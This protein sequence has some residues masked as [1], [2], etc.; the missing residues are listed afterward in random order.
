MLNLKTLI[1][2]LFF[3]AL[4]ITASFIKTQTLIIEKK[5]IEKKKEITVLEKNL[6]ESKLDF[7]YLSSPKELEEK[8]KNISDLNLDTIK[9]SNIYNSFQD[10]F[11][12]YKK[13]SEKK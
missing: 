2:F 9:I 6:Y 12:Q 7:Y 11:N 5:I 1:F 13:L 3:L 8:F 10:F 4:L